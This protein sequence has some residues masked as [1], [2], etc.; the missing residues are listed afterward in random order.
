MYNSIKGLIQCAKKKQVSIWQ[1]VLENECRLSGKTNDEVFRQ[2]EKRY[3]V[4][5]RSVEKAL[6]EPQETVGNLVTGMA[7]KQY[8]Y[9]KKEN[10]LCGPV[11]NHIMAMALSASEVN[12]AMGKICAA[13]T[14]G[15]CGILPTVLVGVSEKYHMAG[16]DVLKGL[17]T[18]S[19]IGTIVVKN[20]T[21]SGAEG[22][23]QAE[24][25]VAAAMAAA[26]AV[27]MVGGTPEMV[28]NAVSITLMNCMGL[29]CDPIAGLV[30]I[31]CAQRNASQSI[32]ALLSADLALAGMEIPIPADEVIDAMYKVGKKLPSELKE[33]A[34][35]GVAATPSG[36]KIEEQI[37]ATK[38]QDRMT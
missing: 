3:E 1:V 35:G 32:N 10:S 23:C 8:L 6:E 34:Q 13:P 17:L 36:K 37:F 22:G 14:A 15:S 28:A 11:L 2:L 31:P 33:T 25:G 21:V 38:Y 4:M 18:A 30:Q 29:V 7:H 19:G 27:D 24:C 5:L 26:A 12:A 9:S 16:K 20:A